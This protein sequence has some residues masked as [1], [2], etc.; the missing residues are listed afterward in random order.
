MFNN[1]SSI[2][3]ESKQSVGTSS[4]IPGVKNTDFDMALTLLK[5]P[6]TWILLFFAVIWYLFFRDSSNG[7]KLA[8]GRWGGSAERLSAKKISL[9]Q[10]KDPKK[11][12]CSLYINTPSQFRTKFEANAKYPLAFSGKKHTE[13]PTIYLPNTQQSVIYVGAAGMGKTYS[14]IDPAVR[15]ALEQGFS[16]VL[17]DFKFPGQAKAHAL[18]AIRRGYKVHILAPGYPES[19]SLNLLDFIKDSTDDAGAEQLA[20]VIV[21]NCNG[22]GAKDNDFFEKA[23]LS[24]VKGSF[25]LAKWIDEY[26]RKKGDDSGYGDLITA[27]CILDLSNLAARLQHAQSNPN[28]NISSWTMK[29][30]SQLISAHGSGEAEA[31]KTE[32]SIVA[33]A[34]GTFAKFIK[35]E[36]IGTFCQKSNLELNVDGK[37]LIILGMNQEKRDAIGPLLAASAHMLIA[38]NI[39]HSKPRTSPLVVSL[40]ELPTLYL[41]ALMRWLAEA[42]SAGFNALIGIQTFTQLQEMYGE[43]NAIT[44]LGNAATKFF[45]NPGTF[46]SAEIISKYIG[47]ED[48]KIKNTSQS[49]GKGGSKSVSVNLQTKAMLAP[50]EVLKMPPGKAVLISSGSAT[51]KESFIPSIQ[52]FKISERDME[53]VNI[54]EGKWDDYIKTVAKTMP[55]LTDEQLETMLS[56]RMKTIAELFP[57]PPPPPK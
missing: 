2:A 4:P 11:N 50:N 6:N 38:G 25:L 48:I 24:V 18:Y 30:F 44:I 37:V 51:K 57:E 35:K 26:F 19:R 21:K 42:R 39:V 15:S 45:F 5:S 52:N 31:N 23:G 43:K 32:A 49:Y 29:P 46:E 47:D 1:Q 8:T 20:E 12:S 40:D 9:K 7:G 55:Q 41:P 56:E 14:G 34:Q 16:V 54:L 36:F 17:Y 13:V 22:G 33:T 10:I 28:L 27:S 3:K 53:E